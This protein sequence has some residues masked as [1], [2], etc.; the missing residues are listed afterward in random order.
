MS[1]TTKYVVTTETHVLYGKSLADLCRKLTTKGLALD[2]VCYD[3]YGWKEG[4]KLFSIQYVAL[5][6]A[7]FKT[8]PETIIP[9]HTEVIPN[10][11][12]LE[13]DRPP[14]VGE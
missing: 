2:G 6:D 9:A 10:T 1:L 14:R 11:H 3:V 5:Y 8:V 4:V 12:G 13:P 7:W